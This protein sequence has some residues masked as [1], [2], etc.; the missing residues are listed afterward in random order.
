MRQNNIFFR[1]RWGNEWIYSE[2]IATNRKD[3]DWVGLWVAIGNTLAFRACPPDSIGMWTGLLDERDTK[4]F[5]GD[6]LA[7]RDPDRPRHTEKYEVFWRNRDCRFYLRHVESGAQK[8]LDILT[9]QNSRV[10]GSM[11]VDKD[12]I[13][14]DDEI[15]RNNKK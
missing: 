10:W 6:I 4:I 7:V 13:K 5:D 11:W 3:K 9:A 2:T 1:G 12:G 14:E 15:E 8:N